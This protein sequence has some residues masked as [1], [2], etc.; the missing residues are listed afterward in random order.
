MGETTTKKLSAAIAFVLIFSASTALLS[1]NINVQ[2]EITTT[3]AASPMQ[4]Q[5]GI[6]LINIQRIDLSASTYRLDFYLWFSF[7]SQQISAIEVS[8]F[9]FING[10]PTVK[11]IDEADGYVEYR[12]TG[13]FLKTFDF[14]RFPFESHALTVELEHTNMSTDILVYDI[15]STSYVEP[16]ANVAGWDSAAFKPK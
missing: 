5:T 12:V 4:V 9:E 11:L 15:D 8:Q 1:M 14:T 6:W 13:D 3:T 10:Q 16:T 7:D 2:A